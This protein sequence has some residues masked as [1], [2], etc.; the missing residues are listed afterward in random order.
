M[1]TVPPSRRRHKKES[2]GNS[3]RDRLRVGVAQ[4]AE[5]INQTERRTS[6][7]LSTGRIPCAQKVGRLWTA[8]ERALRAERGLVD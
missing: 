5:T 7:W 8:S 3:Q 6:Y 2:A 4:I 1:R